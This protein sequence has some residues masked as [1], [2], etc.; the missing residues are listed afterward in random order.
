MSASDVLAEEKLSVKEK[1]IGMLKTPQARALLAVAIGSYILG[2]IFCTF[3]IMG[4]E[5]LED[6]TFSWVNLLLAAITYGFLLFLMAS[7][8]TLVFG[9][10]GVF[11]LAHGAFIA[12]GAYV[13]YQVIVW[14]DRATQVIESKP[15]V[16]KMGSKSLP[17]MNPDGTPKMQDVMVEKG[18]FYSD[19]FTTTTNEAGEQIT[20]FLWGSFSSTV[21]TL[22]IGVLAAA[23]VAGLLGYFFERVMIK[24]VYGNPLNQILITMG[25]SIILIELILAVWHGDTPAFPRPTYIDGRW[26]I[27]VLKDA[28]GM[29]SNV[30]DVDKIRVV[31][32]VLGAVVFFA[33][34]AILNKTKIGLL[35]RAGVESQEM[36][37]VHGYRIKLLFIGVFVAAIC[38]AATGGVMQG[39]WDTAIHPHMADTILISVI[40]AI[41]VGGMG[42]VKGCLVGA[43]LI[44]LVNNYANALLPWVGGVASTVIL[45]VVVLMW[46]PEGLD[47][48]TAH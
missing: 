5:S 11:N 20:S 17:I 40:V 35:I 12:F 36:V 3:N 21:I 24:P 2:L 16:L 1:I 9:L 23:A 13:G 28:A 14:I 31:A 37:E 18:W 33:M 39:L 44:A 7:G 32:G 38:L 25:G 47:P 43:L 30:I 42:S 15:V 41:I 10:M 29:V 22:V 6:W 34:N 45:M 46:R 26:D 19:V 48:V 8:M 4:F 27:Y